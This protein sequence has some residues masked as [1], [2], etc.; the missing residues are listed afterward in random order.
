MPRSSA[1]ANLA[2]SLELQKQIAEAMEELVL[3]SP[4]AAK[5]LVGQ[6]ADL[7]GARPAG[8][9]GGRKPA[10]TDAFKQLRDALL[11]ENPW[12]TRAEMLERTGLSDSAVHALL[13]TSH[14]A[15][16]QTRKNKGGRGN[17]YRLVVDQPPPLDPE[18][19]P[20]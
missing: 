7:V 10:G 14:K 12:L 11:P 16:F 1:F 6:L 18:G 2:R 20:Q 8:A 17:V 4:D 3:H 5:S 15:F 19:E 13:Y 9:G